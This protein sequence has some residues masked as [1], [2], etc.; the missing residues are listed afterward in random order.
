MAGA[1]ESLGSL[2]DEAEGLAV[3][4]PVVVVASVGSA[5]VEVVDLVLGVE[6]RL[7]VLEEVLDDVLD[8]VD[9]VE[10][11]LVEVVD[12]DDV[13]DLVEVDLVE[14]VD[15]DDVLGLVEVAEL[16]VEVVDLDDVL[17]LV[18]L[19]VVEVLDVLDCVVLPLSASLSCGTS[20]SLGPFGPSFS[21]FPLVR[22]L[23]FFSAIERIWFIWA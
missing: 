16:E 7:V 9:V 20:R 6:E 21:T 11:D 12:L 22:V 8:L 10:L 4:V 14:V 23:Y 15:L 17:D 13:V 2:D 1:V 18:V 19:G 3:E 5:V